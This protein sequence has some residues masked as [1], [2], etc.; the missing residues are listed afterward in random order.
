MYRLSAYFAARNISD[1]PLDLIMPTVFLVIVY[2]M[3]GLKLSFPAFSLTLLT[4]FLSIVASQGLGLAIGAAFMDV[5][6]ATT[7]A[8]IILMTFMLSG[9]LFLQKV[10]TF[11]SWVRY[12]S[13]NYHTYR[14]LL[15]IQYPC[16]DPAPG[17]AI[18]NLPFSP[19]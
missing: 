6:K 15:R 19:I 12:I 3:V 16:S 13:F 17:S 5:K 4:V 18:V 8:S 2:F 9:G 10:P 11:M 14:L 7:L 1:L